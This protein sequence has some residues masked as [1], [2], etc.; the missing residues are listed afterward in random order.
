MDTGKNHNIRKAGEYH[1][2][3]ALNGDVCVLLE[4]TNQDE[5]QQLRGYQENLQVRFH[6]KPTRDVHL[7]CQ[8]FSMPE[9]YPQE[10][11]IE[12]LRSAIVDISPFPLTAVAVQKLYVFRKK[13]TILKWRV[14]PTRELS[15]L[16]HRIEEAIGKAGLTSSYIPG[17]VPTLVTAL[18]NI[19]PGSN[20]GAS[21]PKAPFPHYLFMVRKLVISR[22]I[23][24]GQYQLLGTIYLPVPESS[25]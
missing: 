17:W 12:Y 9:D 7:T 2:P 22:I 14:E 19:Q 11:L 4:P 18:E 1:P 6:G 20:I 3:P 8:R 13:S 16:A 23:D 21:R 24:V 25:I 10:V 15:S 5:I